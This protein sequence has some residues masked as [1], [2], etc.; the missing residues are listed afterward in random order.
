MIY[1]SGYSNDNSMNGSEDMP[2]GINL[3]REERSL[4]LCAA[5]RSIVIDL[6]KKEIIK[7]FNFFKYRHVFEVF[8]RN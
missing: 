3:I 7:K 5:D 8:D 1:G 2:H 6:E 4:L